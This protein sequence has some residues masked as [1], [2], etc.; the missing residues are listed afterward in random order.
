MEIIM[1]Y[2]KND[3]QS[4]MHSVLNLNICHIIE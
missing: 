3:C 2:R 1:N 4:A